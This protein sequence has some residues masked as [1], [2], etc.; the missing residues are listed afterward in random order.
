MKKRIALLLALVLCLSLAA[1]GKKDA[2]KDKGPEDIPV[3]TEAAVPE[4]TEPV[5]E[6]FTEPAFETMATVPPTE[7][8]M[9]TVPPTEETE[10]PTEATE[11]TQEE[12]EPEKPAQTSKYSGTPATVT[13]YYEVNLRKG[14]S[15]HS[16][17]VKK[18]RN[19]TQV[20]VLETMDN[21]NAT[22][23]NLGDGWMS[24][25]YLKLSGPLPESP[26]PALGELAKV[27]NTQKLNV[28]SEPNAASELVTTLQR[29]DIVHVH[30]IKMEKGIEWGR[31]DEG[32]VSMEYVLRYSNAKS[33]GSPVNPAIPNVVV[34][35]GNNTVIPTFPAPEG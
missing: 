34:P 12:T 26:D 1:C 29:D 10:A 18:L 31:I 32:W 30:E 14:P 27:Y 20:T 8:T 6:T 2:P 13:G 16:E 24:L 5:F 7:E 17:S 21:E 35:G 3:L 11:E 4:Y 28:R 25:K 22:W 33:Y 15:V 23:A 19:G 9:A